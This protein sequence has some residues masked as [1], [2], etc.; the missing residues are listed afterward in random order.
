M[1]GAMQHFP[2]EDWVDFVREVATEE[3]RARLRDHLNSGCR[4]CI[5]AAKGWESVAKSAKREL[6]YEPPAGSLD[7]ARSY[8]AGHR[9]IASQT[10]SFRVAMLA[11]DSFQRVFAGGIRSGGRAPRQLMYNYGD[12]VIDL[13]VV[14]KPS[15]HQLALVGQVASERED[16]FETDRLQLSVLHNGETLQETNSNEFGEFKLSLPALENLQLLIAMKEAMVVLHLP[17]FDG[18]EQS[19]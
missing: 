10:S 12:M 16:V 1:E 2:I 7:I 9:S 3:Q 5:K 19:M 14:A 8:F 11:F 6:L 17:S 15:S 4:H 13:R 18:E